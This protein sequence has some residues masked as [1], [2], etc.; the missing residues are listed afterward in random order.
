MNLIFLDVDGVLNS[1][2]D[3]FSIELKSK[4]HM[5]HL[6]RVVVEGNASVVISSSWRMSGSL[7]ETLV[8]KLKN[9]KIQV[10]GK[11]PICG[12]RGAEIKIWLSLAKK[13]YM[14][15]DNFVILDD[16]VH[17]IQETELINHL[18]KTDMTIGLQKEDAD[19][20]IA[21]LKDK[22]DIKPV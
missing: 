13:C 12:K 14:D 9:R 2:K 1:A 17:D 19:K 5:H 11:T 16:E 6:K 18:V 22:T 7:Y 3:K 15:I 21:I 10:I 8:T 4:S 20:A